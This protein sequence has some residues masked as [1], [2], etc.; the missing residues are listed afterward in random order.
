MTSSPVYHEFE[1]F[2]IVVGSHIADSYPLHVT[3]LPAGEASSLCHLQIDEELLDALELFEANSA[4]DAYAA[5]FGSFLFTHLFVDHLLALYR[6][7]LGIVRSQGQ[8]LRIRL[9]I[10]AVNL[11]ALP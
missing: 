11:A 3:S 8:Y 6:T 1:S 10:N 4:D 7:S 5:E 2:D 9:Q